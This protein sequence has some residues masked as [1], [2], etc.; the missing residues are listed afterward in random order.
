M[1][2]VSSHNIETV[3]AVSFFTLT[4]WTK[5]CLFGMVFFKPPAAGGLV[6]SVITALDGS[7]NPF[8]KV[9]P[10]A[11]ALAALKLLCP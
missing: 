4:F 8:S 5:I 7:L 10:P 3:Y 6:Q 11:F 9:V 1:T 2:N